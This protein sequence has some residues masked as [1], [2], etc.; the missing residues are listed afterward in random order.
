MELDDEH[1]LHDYGIAEGCTL[2]LVLAMRGGPI[3]TR[4]VTME[5]PV[6]EV[7]DSMEGTK[8]GGWEKSSANKQVTFVVYRE[9]DQLNFFRVVDRG[10]GSLT[11]LSESLRSASTHTHSCFFSGGSVYNMCTEED[12]GSGG[13]RSAAAQSLENS[14]TMSKMKLLKAKMEDMNINKKPKKTSKAKPRPPVGLHPCG[15]NGGGGHPTPSVTRLHQRLVRSLPPINQSRQ[16]TGHLPPIADQ[17]LLDPSPPAAS[18]SSHLPV[19]R[20]P[21]PSFSSPSCYMLQEEEPWESCPPFAKIRPP[22]KVSRLDISGTRLMRDCVYPQLP[23]LCTRGSPEAAF[24]PL[25]PVGEAV[26]V[27]LLEEAGR[28]AAPSQSAAASFGELADPLTCRA[29]DVGAP[30]QLPLPPSPL[31]TWTLGNGGDTLTSRADLAQLSAS[32]HLSPPSPPTSPKPRFQPFDATLPLQ[33]HPAAQVKPGSPSPLPSMMS[34][35]AA[36]LRGVKLESPGKRP[37]LLS[38]REARGIA[39]MANQTCREQLGSLSNSPLMASL[40]ARPVDGSG[41]RRGGLDGPLIFILKS[42]PVLRHCIVTPTTHRTPTY[43]LPPVKT[44]AGAKKKTSKHCFL[45]GKK[46]GLATSYECRCGS[47]FCAAHRYAETHEC[48]YDYKGTGRRFLQDAN[49]LVSAPK[50]PKI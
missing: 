26:G 43:H 32:F 35:H 19:P 49:P 13:E 23:P 8:E 28:L 15:V 29:F 42:P 4:R 1:C 39:K 16:S 5:D 7:A 21:P 11:P 6:K 47:N 40:S 10:D 14:I 36:R 18:T 33:V 17:E 44:P 3:N 9:G 50:L 27:S 38:K 37:E 30:H 12:G 48:S 31:S 46:T 20:Q 41:A 25:K 24:D 45:C 2:K 22:P 34:S